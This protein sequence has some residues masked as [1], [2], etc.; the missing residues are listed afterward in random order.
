LS[1][2]DQDNYAKVEINL[3]N[4]IAPSA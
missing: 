3:P 4:Q 1:S 2:M